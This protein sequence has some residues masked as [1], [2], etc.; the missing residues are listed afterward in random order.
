MGVVIE[1][2]IKYS[3]GPTRIMVTDICTKEW[4]AT[5]GRRTPRPAADRGALCCGWA[6]YIYIRAYAMGGGRMR[7]EP[8]R[9]GREDVSTA[10]RDWAKWDLFW[11]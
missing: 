8:R 11:F 9:G 3:G 1:I 5:S 10:G 4:R 2:F 6:K 7:R